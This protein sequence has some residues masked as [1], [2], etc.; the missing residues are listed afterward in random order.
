MEGEE[1]SN[2]ASCRDKFFTRM[3]IPNSVAGRLEEA[4]RVRLKHACAHQTSLGSQPYNIDT[5]SREEDRSSRVG[6]RV[7]NSLHPPSRPDRGSLERVR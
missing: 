1:F 6:K 4:Q 5:H 7:A 2:K 3:F